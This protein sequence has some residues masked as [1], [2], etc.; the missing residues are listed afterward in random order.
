MPA[1]A[2]ASIALALNAQGA[3]SAG[4]QWVH[5]TPSGK[6]SGRDGRGP[7]N[8]PD[9]N[10]VITATNSR[11]G[12]AL[13]VDYDHQIDQSEK[14]GQPAPAAGWIKELDAR[15]SGIWGRIEWTARAAAHIAAREYRFISPVFHYRPDTGEVMALAR[16]ALTN[17]PNL[18]LVA[19]A[20]AQSGNPMTELEELQELLGLNGS[21]NLSDVVAGVRTLVT[22]KAANT[23]DSSSFVP[24]AVF[25]QVTA[26]LNA[27]NQG[28]SEELAVNHVEAVMS[29]GKLIPFLKDWA[30]DLCRRD[31][32]A[33]DQFLEKTA[34]A[35]FQRLMEPI[36]H[37]KGKPPTHDLRLSETET[38]IARQLGHSDEEFIAANRSRMS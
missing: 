4:G 28:M 1:T 34:G 18:E 16:A 12:D 37:L 6:F 17:N 14:N 38:A 8:V 10:K 22:Q 2:S 31:R 20:R 11:Q 15:T 29:K 23:P 25:E 36:P 33:F 27:R 3:S 26:E 21:A 32:P 9:P 5:L 30:V 24:M 7:W 35:P 13:P 19:L